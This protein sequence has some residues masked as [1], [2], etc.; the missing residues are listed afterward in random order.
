MAHA[1]GA[2]VLWDLSHTAGAIPVHLKDNGSISRSAAPTS[3]STAAPARPR[4]STSHERLQ[5][6]L[7]QPIWGWLGRADP[8][9]MGPGYEP[10]PG[11]TSFT[12]GTPPI[13]GADGGTR[14]DRA[15]DRG[16]DRR[17]PRQVDKTHRVRDRT[18]RR[19][20]RNRS[21]SRSGSPRDKG[22]RGGHVALVHENARAL[23]E[24]ARRPQRAR[25]LPRPGRDPHRPV[26]ADHP[27]HRRLRRPAHPQGSDQLAAVAHIFVTRQLPGPALDRLNNQHDVEIWPDRLP[28]SYEEL[29]AQVQQRGRAA[30]HD[31]RPHRRAADR[32]RRQPQ[33][34]R[35]LRRRLRQRRRR[36]RHPTRDPGRQ[37]A[38]RA[39]RRDRRPRVHA[40]AG[41]RAPAARGDRHRHRRRPGTRGIPSGLLGARST[42]RRSGS[43]APGG[44]AR[45]SPS[46]PPASRWRCCSPGGHARRP[47]RR[48]ERDN[49]S[50]GRTHILELLQR[51]DFIS[52]H[53]PLT[54]QTRHL[55]DTEALRLMKPTAILVNT[56]RGPIV[57]QR[58]LAAAL[59]DG[60]IAGAALDVTDPEPL[61]ADDPL[62]GG[63]QPDRRRRTSARRRTRRVSR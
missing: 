26:A 55:I 57:D 47:R 52:I 58:A 40:A 17:D 36:R 7:R 25:R 50:T 33:G 42:A 2:L 46:A 44:S 59:K 8:F 43:S 14:R 4:S 10:A 30:L 41:R 6:A 18:R 51:S 31:L 1:A 19:T 56:A 60:Q 62:L 37:H 28:P 23:T 29:T 16:R 48:H 45:R 63:A 49:H 13:L 22:R 15:V 12:T 9:E 61:P 34:D 11:I 38:R 21:G 54:A 53:C 27:F 35:Q 24:T 3:T 32:R 20:A 39:D 5:P